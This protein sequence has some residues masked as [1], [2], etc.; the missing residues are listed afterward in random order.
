[1]SIGI[2]IS[3]EGFLTL[4]RNLH[5]AQILPPL[6]GQIAVFVTLP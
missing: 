5:N 3:T 4:I 6:L 2:L 1:M